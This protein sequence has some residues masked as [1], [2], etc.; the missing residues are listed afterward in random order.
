MRAPRAAPHPEI[1]PALDSALLMSFHGG[2]RNRNALVRVYPPTG[3]SLYS[4]ARNVTREIL[5]Y[6]YTCS[7]IKA[8]HPSLGAVL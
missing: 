2:R 7:R 3:P 4:A 1:I 8:F 6:H 5:D